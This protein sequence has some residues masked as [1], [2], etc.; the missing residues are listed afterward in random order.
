MATLKAL[1]A[2][3]VAQESPNDTDQLE[4]ANSGFKM[5]SG[6]PMEPNLEVT[7]AVLS[8]SHFG[9]SIIAANTAF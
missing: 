8:V 5:L 1:E 7:V 4:A 2:A 6:K 3:R 9:C